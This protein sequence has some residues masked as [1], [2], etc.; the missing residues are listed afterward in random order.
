M[1]DD[2]EEWKKKYDELSVKHEGLLKELGEWK[3]KCE[4]QEI[5]IR[6]LQSDGCCDVKEE[7]KQIDDKK[8]FTGLAV[9]IEKT[10]EKVDWFKTKSPILHD[11][12]YKE[13]F[14]W[15]ELP[16]AQNAKFNPELLLDLFFLAMS[17]GLGIKA[18]TR[19]VKVDGEKV[20]R[21]TVQRWFDRTLD[22]L[23]NWGLKQI[24]W[25]SLKEWKEDCKRHNQPEYLKYQKVLFFHIDGSIVETFD[26]SDPA[27]RRAIRNGK[28]GCP[29][30]VFFIIVT[31]RGRIVYLSKEVKEGSVNDKSHV[32]D[33]KVV[34]QLKDVYGEEGKGRI[35]D[36]EYLFSF[37]GDKAYPFMKLPPHWKL[38]VT[39]T[40][41]DTIETDERGN[42]IGPKAK[43]A[44][45]PNVE[46]DSAVARLRSV[47]ERVILRVKSWP[48]FNCS[49]HC[50]T[51]IRVKKLL[52]IS[53]GLVNWFLKHDDRYEN[54]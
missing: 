44:K 46:F 42:A 47:V 43:D 26:T 50:S 10:E 49:P 21:Q 18:L 37:C 29:A 41:E 51:V 20:T 3:R 4:D 12:L 13:L 31:S 33:E 22:C 15:I 27:G 7:P 16:T 36:E 6:A 17:T 8:K 23:E 32:N 9:K 5:L 14:S 39:K 25:V 1:H 30:F 19:V 52:I 2:V 48:I 28:H 38:Y 54:I 34:E 35:D 53:C 40:G 11:A 45:L 24:T